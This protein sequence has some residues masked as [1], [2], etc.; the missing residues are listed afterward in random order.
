MKSGAIKLRGPNRAGCAGVAAKLLIVPLSVFLFA[1]H[2]LAG[3]TPYT[4]GQIQGMVFVQ[5]SQGQSCVPNAKVML[6]APVVME[7]KTDESGKFEFRDVPPGTYIIAVEAPGLV[8]TQEVTI[9][10]AKVAQFS[11]ELKPT[12]KQSLPGS[13][14]PADCCCLARQ[15]SAGGLYHICCWKMNFCRLYTTRTATPPAKPRQLGE[16]I[17]VPGKRVSMR[18]TREVLR[19]YFD[20]KLGAAADNPQRQRQPEHGA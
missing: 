5:D 17:G 1:M 10:V 18:K 9:E 11:L 12:S 20:L 3:Q 6:Q 2:V 15:A 14:A 8:A 19:F 4:M 16:H 13:D 7:T